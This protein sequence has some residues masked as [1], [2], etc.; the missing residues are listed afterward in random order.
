[1]LLS[2]RCHLVCTNC[3]AAHRACSGTFPCKRCR[4]SNRDC[5]EAPPWSPPVKTR[6]KTTKRK[7]RESSHDA[8]LPEILTSDIVSG[9]SDAAIDPHAVAK[10]VDANEENSAKAVPS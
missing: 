4:D 6:Q 8:S 7:G 5:I 9:R 3:R 2:D 1:M 10:A